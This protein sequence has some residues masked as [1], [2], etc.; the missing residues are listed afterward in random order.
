M[1]SSTCEIS[2]LIQQ[3]LLYRFLLPMVS[4]IRR[5]RMNKKS[6]W[7][8]W[9]ASS[10]EFPFS[11]REFVSFFID[12]R[13]VQN[14]D[15]FLVRFHAGDVDFDSRKHSTTGFCYDHFCSN[16]KKLGKKGKIDFQRDFFQNKKPRT[17]FLKTKPQIK[18]MK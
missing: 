13:E 15:V 16:L 8:I 18:S 4:S 12:I 5:V 11:I 14:D 2:K 9:L 7:M 10:P 1:K 3:M 17:G 6:F